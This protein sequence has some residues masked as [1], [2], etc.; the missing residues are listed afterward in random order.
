MSDSSFTAKKIE[1]R[2]TLGRG[3]FGADAGNT[4][5]VSGLRTVCEIEKS[6]EPSK[7]QMTLKIYGMLQ[8]DMNTISPQE[9]SALAQQKNVVQVFAGD[10]ESGMPMAFSGD[11]TEAWS[12]YK[13]PPDLYFHIKAIAGYYPSLAPAQ[14]KSYS[15][16]TPVEV[17]MAAL[18]SDM[19][20]TFENRD[21]TTSLMSPY[22]AGSAM[23]QAKMVAE[24]ANLEFGVDDDV[25]FIA[26]RGAARLGSAQNVP[27]ISAAT[28]MKEYPIFGKKG[29][30]VT[31]L[32]N[33]NI[34]L[35]GLIKVA[36]IVPNANGVWRVN[37][38]K[39]SLESEKP[40][41]HWFTKVKAV[42]LNSI[43]S[44]AQEGE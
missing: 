24:A 36:S 33:P 23:Q 1:V 29:L 31:T 7:N 12:V 28:G 22:L 30:E 44:A 43:D 37:G 21:V 14:P 9:G 2:V 15:G 4:K 40:G 17:I 42:H 5:I 35:G 27:F 41:A 39:H 3:T 13:S 34:K 8:A 19:G 32:Y 20:Y 11:I 26:P 10:D 16:A 6:G 18:A 25:L 38:L